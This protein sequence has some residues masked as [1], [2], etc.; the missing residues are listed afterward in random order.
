MMPLDG[1]RLAFDLRASGDF[2]HYTD[3]DGWLAAAP[4]I[5]RASSPVGGPLAPSRGDQRLPPE[6]AA[7]VEIDGLTGAWI[8]APPR[9]T[10]DLTARS[11]RWVYYLLTTR[12]VAGSPKIEDR[13]SAAALSFAV[14]ELSDETSTLDDPTGGRL[15][16]ARPGGRCFRLTSAS[17]VPSRRTPRRHLAL[18]LG[19]DLLIPELANPSIRSRSRLRAAA[20]D[21]PDSTLFRVLEF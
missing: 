16:A 3:V 5:Y 10:L 8:A 20:Q 17:R 12:A 11:A 15:V 1:L 13:G 21:E 18:L 6:V 19:E 7:A 2:I 4:T 9:Y 14:A